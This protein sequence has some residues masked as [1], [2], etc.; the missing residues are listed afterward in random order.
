M[1]SQSVAYALGGTLSEQQRLMAQA[2]GLEVH[3]E[4][5]LD[6][7]GVSAGQRTVDVGCGPIGILNLLSDRG[8]RRRS[9]WR[10]KRAAFFR[11]RPGRVGPPSLTK[12]QIGQG[13]RL[14][15]RT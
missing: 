12:C 11:Y 7:I 14:G 8:S 4:W 2:Q 5:L 1:P 10:R 3:A 6:Q 15:Y 9:N 13:R